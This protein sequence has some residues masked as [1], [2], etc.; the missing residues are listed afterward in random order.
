MAQPWPGS[1]KGIGGLKVWS[2]KLQIEIKNFFV[3]DEYSEIIREMTKPKESHP[4]VTM[5]LITSHRGMHAHG[6]Q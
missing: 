6:A 1:T 3:N 5:F 2:D 4:K